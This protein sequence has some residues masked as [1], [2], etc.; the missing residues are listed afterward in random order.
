MV[1]LTMIHDAAGTAAPAFAVRAKAGLR[2]VWRQL[3]VIGRLRAAGELERLASGY[4][5]SQPQLA[6]HMREA[7][8]ECLS[9][10]PR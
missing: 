9:E 4:A 5:L 3:E 8:R 10:V 6:A 2:A 7:A 1:T